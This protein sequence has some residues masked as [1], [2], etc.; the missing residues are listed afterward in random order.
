MNG[1][2]QTL[3]LLELRA[4]TDRQ[5]LQLISVRLHTALRLAKNRECVAE[6]EDIHREVSALLPWVWGV[7]G[8]ERRELES[9]T[10]DLRRLLDRFSSDAELQTQSACS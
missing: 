6:A 2:A 8:A 3:K 7:S 5:L 9:A 1:T 10:G 4:K